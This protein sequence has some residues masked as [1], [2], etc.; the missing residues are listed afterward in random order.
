MAS[1]IHLTLAPDLAVHLKRN[2]R[3]RRL[4]L[5]VS[6]VDGRVT[7]TVPPGVTE[8]AARAFANEK[9]GWI[10]DTVARCHAPVPVKIGAEVPIA[11]HPCCIVAGKGRAARLFEARI[12]APQDRAGPATRALI[13]HLARARLAAATERFA[14]AL[15]K[16]PGRLTLRDTRS[17]WGSCTSEGNLMFSWRLVMAP[18]EVLD[19]VAA[20][21]VAHL[22]HMD[23]SRRF[24]DAVERLYPGFEAPRDW[25]RSNGASLHRYRFETEDG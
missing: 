20:H 16:I 19:Y 23:H 21:E 12:E 1:A 6:S 5:R 3:A 2:S 8:R 4:S 13:K 15:D 25:L 7:L 17:R 9:A 22:Q 18:V 10:R 14:T 11:D 24:W